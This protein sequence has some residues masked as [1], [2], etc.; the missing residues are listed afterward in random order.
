MEVEK[1]TNSHHM[2]VYSNVGPTLYTWLFSVVHSWL[3][4]SFINSD[5]LVNPLLTMIGNTEVTLDL[6]EAIAGDSV[7]KPFVADEFTF[8]SVV[9]PC[10]FIS[11]HNN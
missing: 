11:A 5:T 7:V 9:I 4:E 10:R 8:R 3:D 2:F 1:S 6:L